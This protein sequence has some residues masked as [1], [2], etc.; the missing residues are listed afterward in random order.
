MPR[1][2]TRHLLAT[3]GL[4]LPLLLAGCS[5]SDVS[6]GAVTPA[7]DTAAIG[8]AVGAPAGGEAYEAGPVSAVDTSAAS[9]GGQPVG[10][11]R[12]VV[13]TG[14]M[15]V[16]VDDV[17]AAAAKVRARV[18]ALGGQM[19]NEDIG[20]QSEAAY[21]SLV[22][23]VPAD[24]LDGFI[25]SVGQLGQVMSENVS[26]SDVTSQVVDL[27]AR[28][29]ALR[30]SVQRMQELLAQASKIGDLLAIE[31]QLSQRQSELDALA[32][33]RAYLSEQVALSTMTV[34]LSPVVAPVAPEAPGFLSGLESGWSAF[35]SALAVVVT[36]TGFLLPFAV[37]GGLLVGFAYAL[38]RLLSRR[39]GGPTSGDS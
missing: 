10:A 28:I 33:Q 24:R 11:D 23:Q 3:L 35:T 32:A 14:V 9:R 39:R 12:Q 2:R 19:A 21:A 36:A 30:T 1:L 20:G 7:G 5:S 18:D 16:R 31:T 13:R 17:L 34:N 4:T 6:S 15:D 37:L 22:A 25:A 38:V 29:R 27:D 26:S 8:V